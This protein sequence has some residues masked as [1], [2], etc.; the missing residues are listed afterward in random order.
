MKL[1]GVTLP[2]LA[3]PAP[4]VQVQRWLGDREGRHVRRA[5]AVDGRA[6]VEVRGARAHEHRAVGPAVKEAL[7]RLEGVEWAEVDAILGRAVILFDPE[8]IEVDDI[9]S[10]LEDVE[11]AHGLADE[12]F[13][14]HLPDHPDDLEPVQRR[15]FAVGADLVGL[16]VVAAGQTLRLARIPAEIPGLVSLADSQP[17]IRRAIEDRLGP[18]ATD[19]VV[20]GANAAA[21]ALGQGALGLMVD[22]TQHGVRIGEQLARR[23]AWRAHEHRFIEGP[24]SV[25][26]DAVELPPRPVPLPKGPIESYADGAAIGSLGAVGVTLGLKPTNPR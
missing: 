19:L 12:R 4:I 2:S 25:R 6:H 15:A 9:V 14:H 17:R 13:P 10:T 21:Q 16:G 7:E 23:S 24:H 8:A 3:L 1:P 20:A 18:P 22:V 11:E 26:H 5:S